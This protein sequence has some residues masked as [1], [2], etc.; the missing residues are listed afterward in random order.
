MPNTKT[1]IPILM[2][3]PVSRSSFARGHVNEEQL[4]AASD[5]LPPLPNSCAALCPKGDREELFCKAQPVVWPFSKNPS[6]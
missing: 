4:M 2:V 3:K 1:Q 5:R 6:E